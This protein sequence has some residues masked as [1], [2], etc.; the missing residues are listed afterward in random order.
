ML[1]AGDI[2]TLSVSVSIDERITQKKNKLNLKN[3]YGTK[4]FCWTLCSHHVRSSYI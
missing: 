4:R 2:L 1:L 3:P